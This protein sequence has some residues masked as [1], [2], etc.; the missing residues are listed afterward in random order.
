MCQIM[1][2]IVNERPSLHRQGPTIICFC[3]SKSI[4]LIYP[5]KPSMYLVY[6][7]IVFSF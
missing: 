6:P 2:P 3:A 5:K 4:F 1:G 7:E